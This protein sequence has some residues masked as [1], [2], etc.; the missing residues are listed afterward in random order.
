MAARKYI[1]ILRC[2]IM[3]NLISIFTVDNLFFLKNKQIIKVFTI[4]LFLQIHHFI[5]FG[6][7]D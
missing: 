6:V 5:I 3:Y 7:F 1:I 4:F 2:D